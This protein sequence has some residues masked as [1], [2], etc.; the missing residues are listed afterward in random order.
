MVS[1]ITDAFTAPEQVTVIKRFNVNVIGAGKPTLLFCNGFNCNQHIWNYLTPALAGR[2]QLVLFDQMG[3][4]DSDLSA[5]DAAKYASLAGYAQDVVDI[6]Q[7]LE[8][9]EVIIIGHSVGAMIALLAAIQAPQYFAKAVLIAASPCYLNEPGYY[10]GF[11]RADMLDLLAEM[12]GN[13]ESWANTFATLLIGQDQPASLGYELAGYFCQADPS[14]ARE[15]AHMGFLA[16]NRAD[17]PHLHLPTL[18]LQCSD[19]VA[20][21]V[22]VGDYLLANLPQGQLIT[23]RATGHCPH[24]SAPMEVLAALRDFISY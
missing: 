9:R 22:E 18:L 5:Y 2:H 21:P 17:V 16:D 24:L 15:F 4:G 23:L 13:Y 6:C 1:N 19:D 14:I 7:A 20:V 12:R 8:L 3:T 11:E 10:G